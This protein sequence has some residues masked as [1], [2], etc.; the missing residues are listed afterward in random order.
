MQERLDYGNEH[1]SRRDEYQEDTHWE[2]E[3]YR[4]YHRLDDKDRY[5]GYEDE[6]DFGEDP[7]TDFAQDTATDHQ[8]QYELG[9]SAGARYAAAKFPEYLRK[10]RG[11]INGKKWRPPYERG[12]FMPVFVKLHPVRPEGDPDYPVRPEEDPD[13][14]DGIPYHEEALPMMSLYHSRNLGIPYH[15][16]APPMP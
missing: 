6:D 12:H 13:Y 1:E 10:G 5:D 15:E 4:I 7:A 9:D 11:L 2:L 3:E 14:A 16:E 8:E